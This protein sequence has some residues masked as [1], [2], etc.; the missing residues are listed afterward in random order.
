MPERIT[1]SVKAAIEPA[2]NQSAK[3]E[4]FSE[5]S[6][7]HPVDLSLARLAAASERLSLQC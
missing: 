6:W 3:L 7:H 1:M 4:L 5:K 2:R